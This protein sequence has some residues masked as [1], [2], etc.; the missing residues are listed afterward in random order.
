METSRP[1]RG[2]ARLAAAIVAALLV[3]LSAAGVA[4][5]KTRSSAS[6]GTGVAVVETELA[7][8]NGEAAGTGIVLTSSG[9]ILT[10][11]HVI[12]GATSITVIIPGTG[13][14]FTAKV[15]GYDVTDDV[16]VLKAT[17]ASNLTTATLGNSAAVKLGQSV[18]AVGN[19]GGTG[20]LSTA[21]GTV[22]ALRRAITVSDDQGGSAR[23]TGLIETN[24]ALQ[25]GDSGGPLYA[26]GKVIG[27]NTAATVG[28]GPREISSTG[29][30]AIPINKA[31][32]I[33]R[34]IESGTST[35]K[36]HVGSTAFLGVTV[37]SSD[38]T[39][40]AVGAVVAG[41]LSGG[42]AA[43]AGITPGDVITSFGGT[44]VTSP[45]KLTSLVLARK[46]GARVSLTYVDRAGASH[47]VTV[48]LASGPP[49]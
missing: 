23:L 10:N 17:G 27:V 3:A 14:S 34:R 49:Q 6:V 44:R 12:R 7:Y 45:S 15:V 41:V 1:G 11:N 2:S 30:Y 37:G 32:G 42:P 35:A 24:A 38:Y 19:A 26:A 8:E 39:D 18:R 5:A 36:V 9:E 13:R 47:T 33:V 4:L 46:P 20:S 21:T 25:S 29:G 16:A 48:R 40:T 28:Y 22:T 31:I 43:A